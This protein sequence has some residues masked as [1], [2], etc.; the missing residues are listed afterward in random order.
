MRSLKNIFIVLSKGGLFL[1]TGIVSILLVSF[2]EEQMINREFIFD[3]ALF[4]VIILF[5]FLLA[6][7]IKLIE[8]YLYILFIKR[9]RKNIVISSFLAI[10]GAILYKWIDVLY[11]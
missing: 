8:Y 10:S 6:I 3:W 9:S 2:V 7:F 5:L 1:L 4:Q 11:L